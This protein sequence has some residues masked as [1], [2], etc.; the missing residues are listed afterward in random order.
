MSMTITYSTRIDAA[1]GPLLMAKDILDQII[2]NCDD[3]AACDLANVL[4]ADL[5]VMAVQRL[6]GKVSSEAHDTIVNFGALK[7]TLA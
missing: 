6:T 7:K 5:I 2:P 1:F 4:A 3:E